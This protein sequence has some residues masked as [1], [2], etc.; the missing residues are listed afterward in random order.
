LG[1]YIYIYIYIY[2]YGAT[3]NQP[4]EAQTGKHTIALVWEVQHLAGRLNPVSSLFVLC[5]VVCFVSAL[6]ESA[7]R[8]LR[9]GTCNSNPQRYWTTLP[10][11]LKA[12]DMEQQ[13]CQ[14]SFYD[15]LRQFD[16]ILVLYKDIV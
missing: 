12:M 10:Q 6:L 13:R 14:F 16:L 2:T 7:G 5:F 9:P 3:P 8:P 11:Y 1:I 4:Q 15:P